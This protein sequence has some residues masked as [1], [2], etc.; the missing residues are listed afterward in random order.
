MLQ[1]HLGRQA[2]TIH[3]SVDDGSQVNQ[4]NALRKPAHL[5]SHPAAESAAGLSSI[6]HEEMLI[7]PAKDQIASWSGRTETKKTGTDG[8]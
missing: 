6:G 5:P 3:K 4:K 7:C 2:H 8:R 1:K